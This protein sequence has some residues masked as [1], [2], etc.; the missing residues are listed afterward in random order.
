MRTDMIPP[1]SL[2]SLIHI[3]VIVPIVQLHP[4]HIQAM[5]AVEYIQRCVE[6]ACG[7]VP[8]VFFKQHAFIHCYFLLAKTWILPLQQRLPVGIDFW[9]RWA[10][11]R[12]PVW[13]HL[14]V[15]RIARLVP[16]QYIVK[17]DLLFDAREGMR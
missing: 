11:V 3:H 13:V 15:E 10:K 8:V 1:R 7:R 9:A 14:A 6:L 4:H 5:Q 16:E 2:V 17:A 12:N